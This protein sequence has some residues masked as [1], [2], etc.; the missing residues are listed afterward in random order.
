MVTLFTFRGALPVES[1]TGFAV[2]RAARLDLS[3]DLGACSDD[4]CAMTV[5]GPTALVDAFEMAVSLGPQDCIVLEI[6][7]KDRP[8]AE[9]PSPERIAHA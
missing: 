6:D 4:I 1:F 9:Y 3:L 8:L 2:H 7:R 5:S